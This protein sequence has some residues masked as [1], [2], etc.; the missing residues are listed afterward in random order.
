LEERLVG[1][2]GMFGRNIISAIKL[3][4]GVCG[5][6]VTDYVYRRNSQRKRYHLEV[7]TLDLREVVCRPMDLTDL[8]QD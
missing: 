7:L 4:E 6:S 2:Q 8:D 5:L 1:P 3:R